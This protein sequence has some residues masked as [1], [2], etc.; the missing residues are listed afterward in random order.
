MTNNNGVFEAEVH[1]NVDHAFIVALLTIVDEIDTFKLHKIANAAGEV[2][3]GALEGMD[4]AAT[5]GQLA[6]EQMDYEN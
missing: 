3:E 4:V 1:P 6:I 5:V 2:A